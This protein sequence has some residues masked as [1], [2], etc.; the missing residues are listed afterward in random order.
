MGSKKKLTIAL[1]QLA[2]PPGAPEKNFQKGEKM[3]RDAAV[4]GADL[5]LLPELWV[6]GYDLKNCEKYASQ[7]GGGWFKR[8]AGLAAENEV[9]LGGSLIEANRDGFYNTFVFYDQQG[10]LRST[11]RKIHLFQL[12]GEQK[13]FKGGDR[14][15]V[16]DTAWGKIGLAICYDLRFPEIFRSYGIGGVELII[17][18]AVW[19]QRRIDHW[20]QLLIARAIEN[21]CYIAG[22]NKVGESGG[23]IF[24]GG[25]AVVT[26]MGEVLVQGGDDEDLLF[27]SIDL[28]E[29]A[30]IR[31]WMP[32]FDD[33]KPDIYQKPLNE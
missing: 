19:P 4:G 14:L 25:S 17:I 22:V 3:V 23:E 16:V 2:L 30:K 9:A 7:I 26:P 29:V 27:A 15:V 13:Y 21:Q 31:R 8:M 5:V 12:T 11:Y 20:R 24:G 10:K 6:S 32:V 28:T 18:A 1:A 33:R